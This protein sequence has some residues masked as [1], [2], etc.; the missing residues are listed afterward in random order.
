M[1][2]E[3]III[4]EGKYDK[5]KLESLV[6]ATILTTDGF[7]LYR[8]KEKQA[9]LRKAALRRGV[10]VLTDSDR[11]GIRIRNL[12]KNIVGSDAVVKHA[13]I[14]EI[15]GKERRKTAPSAE[16]L[17][18]VEGMPKEELLTVLERVCTPAPEGRRVTKT[19]LYE[20]GLSGGTGSAE[21]RKTLARSL[22]LPEKLSANALLDYINA[23]CTYEEFIELTKED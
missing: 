2:I 1:R 10:I 4:V 21:K 18:G 22:R 11:A 23:V 3:E 8:D 5:I 9:A 20:A 7:R 14:P 19:D 12:I 16:G 15:H 6:D 17:L 13:Y